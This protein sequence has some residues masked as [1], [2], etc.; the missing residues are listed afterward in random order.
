MSNP[1]ETGYITGRT[2]YVVIHYNGQVWNTGTNLFENYN[3]A[4]WANYAISLN[5]Q[6]GS[7]YYSASYPSQIA[8][9][10]LSTEVIYQQTGGS[11]ALGD[12]IIGLG[13]S[14]GVN[15]MQVAYDQNA[16]L[17]FQKSAS[18]IVQA[19]AVTGTLSTTQMTTNLTVAVNDF[20]VGRIIIWTSGSLQN[21]ATNI[22]AY[23]GATKKLTFTAVTSAPANNDT[24]VIV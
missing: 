17:N 23:D 13:A 18:T 10:T 8:A 5:E 2:I 12:T 21:Q 7:G 1:I 14:Q 22:T 19:T 6:S 20:Y 15:M 11:P 4:H 16:V 3:S 9:G 24:F